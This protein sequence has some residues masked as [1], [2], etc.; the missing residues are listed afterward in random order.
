M[1][2]AIVLSVALVAGLAELAG[3][4]HAQEVARIDLVPELKALCEDDDASACTRLGDRLIE[5]NGI[6]RDDALGVATLGKA[7]QLGDMP[8]CT[9]TGF[10]Y[11]KGQGVA[12]SADIARAYYAYACHG[13]EATG[14]SNL[15]LAY[16]NG[17]GVPKDDARA[18]ALFEQ[19]CT[20]DSTAGCANL[21]AGTRR[22]ARSSPGSTVVQTSL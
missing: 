7:C 19:A 2:R 8:G 18:A 16:I 17:V 1:I 6:G 13:G 21:G 12:Q 22:A 11:G 14:C 15:G 9:M 20:N 3:P 5:G 10:A 4:T